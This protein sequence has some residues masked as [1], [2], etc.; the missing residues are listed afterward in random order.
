LTA[1]A[2]GVVTILGASGSFDNG[3]PVTE[4]VAQIFTPR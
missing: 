2:S 1:L 4:V 3:R